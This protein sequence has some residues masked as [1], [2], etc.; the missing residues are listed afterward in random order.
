[1]ATFDEAKVA[2]IVDIVFI[3]EDG[4]LKIEYKEQE[5]SQIVGN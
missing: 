5:F 4:I 1:M 3:Q 2:E